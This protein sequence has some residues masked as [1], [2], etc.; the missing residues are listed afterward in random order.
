MGLLQVERDGRSAGVEAVFG[1]VFTERDDAVLDLIGRATR[2][3]S[4][5]TR[6]W[7]EP[8]LAFS[9]V[10]GD[11]YL[12]PP[13]RDVVIAGDL[14]FRPPLGKNSCDDDPGQRHGPHP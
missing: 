3:C 4:R 6:A 1:E 13:P 9:K 8:G 5:P 2:R 11:E 14:R 12:Y 10:T 7:L